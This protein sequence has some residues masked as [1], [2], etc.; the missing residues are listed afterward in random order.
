MC[1]TKCNELQKSDTSYY[2]TTP[3][4]NKSVLLYY[5]FKSSVDWL[6][7][8][9][10]MLALFGAHLPRETHCPDCCLV[11]GM[12]WWTQ[13]LSSVMKRRKICIGLRLNNARYFFEIVTRLRGTHHSKSKPLNHM[14]FSPIDQHQIFDFSNYFACSDHSMRTQWKSVIHLLT[15][16]IASAEFPWFLSNLSLDWVIYFFFKE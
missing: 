12:L 3:V 10:E 2:F 8:S 1:W 16:V 13:A 5:F 6:N 7:K 14:I 4:S 15:I 11:S 9:F